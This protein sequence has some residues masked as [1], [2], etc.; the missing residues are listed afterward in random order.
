MRHLTK[1]LLA[2]ATLFASTAS[3]A[4]DPAEFANPSNQYKPRTWMHIMCG[5]LSKEGFTQDFEALADADIGGALVFHIDRGIPCGPVEFGSEEFNDILAH[6]AVEAQRVGIE[7]GLHNCDGWSSSGGP[8]VTPEQSMKKVVFA[9]TVV[10]GGRQSITLPRP[11]RS[12]DFYRDIAVLAWPASNDVQQLA[13]QTANLSASAARNGIEALQDGNID[14]ETIITAADDGKIWIQASYPEP[15]TIKSI[16]TEQRSRHGVFTLYTSDD[17]ESFQEV[18]TL[19]NGRIGKNHWTSTQSF[20]DGLTAKHFRLI[21]DQSFPVSRFELVAYPRLPNWQVNN[22]MV[23]AEANPYDTLPTDAIIAPSDIHI[24]HQGNLESDTLKTNL[25]K[26]KWLITRYGYTTTNAFNNPA[27]DAGRGLEIDKLDAAALDHHF[28]QYVGKVVKEAQARGSNALLYSEIDSYEMGGN[29]WTANLDQLF[30]DRWGYD[31]TKWLPTFNGHVIESNAATHAVLTDMRDLVA[32]LMTQNYFRRFSELCHEHGMLAYN[33]PY[34]FGTLNELEVGG[35]AD[36]TMGEFWVREEGFDGFFNAAVS[37]ARIYGNK[38]ISAESFTSWH[39]VNWRGHPFSMKVYGDHAWTQGINETM[40]HRYAH[41]P[42]THVIPGMTMGSVGSH[43]DRNQTW[44]HNAGKAWF[45]YLARGSYL[46]QQGL[47]VSD[48]LIF[49]GDKRPNQIPLWNSG[50]IPAGYRGDFVNADVL[51]HRITVQDGKLVLPEGI[52]YKALYLHNS[53]Q[54]RLATLQRLEE[55]VARGATILGLAPSKPIGYREQTEKS[56]TFSNIVSKLW[57]S[58]TEPTH[59]KKGTVIP[60][61]QIADGLAYLQLGPDLIVN[62][63]PSA[64]FIRRSIGDGTLYFL[65]NESKE[66]QDMQ[67]DFRVTGLTPEIW[68]ADTGTVEQV[69]DYQSDALRTRFRLTVEP[70]GSRFVYFR[71]G[72][73]PEFTPSKLQLLDTLGQTAKT[74]EPEALPLDLDWQVTFDKNW[75]GPGQI[76]M[77]ELQDWTEH[78]EDGVRHFSGTAVYNATFELPANWA[79]TDTPVALDLG[80]VKIA[81]VITINGQRFPTLWKPPFAHDISSALKPGPNSIQVEVTN[82]WTNRLIGDEAHPANDDY[83][84]NGT[85]P[86]WFSKN[87]PAPASDRYTWTSWNFYATDELKTLEPSGLIGPVRLVK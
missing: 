57:A 58:E 43:I 49:T 38:V 28:E 71:K 37:S 70:H 84:L 20:T 81:A 29:N 23:S 78:S 56:D 35:T 15:V 27:S 39:Q 47:P 34:G 7:M 30:S 62:G 3:A 77:P 52:S 10:N 59:Y 61:A 69:V 16:V 21:L 48:F 1:T 72:K 79:N 54:L 75:G 82:V 22:A 73:A 36:K 18:G 66:Y 85:M 64:D 80:E 24:L 87:E 11:D 17:G 31:L 6:A 5:N 67:L 26:G 63:A 51:I 8:W 44:W 2:T 60:T 9:E 55:L 68:D 86:E 13:T 40:F 46:L 41:Q 4:P 42:N 76:A 50:I 45:K 25:P 53:D 65:F 14:T 83:D 12:R 32:D 19:N 33:E 74:D